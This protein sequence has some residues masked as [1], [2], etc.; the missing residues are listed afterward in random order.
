MKLKLPSWDAFGRALLDQLKVLEEGTSVY[1]VIE[2]DDGYIEAWDT[3]IYFSGPDEWHDAELELL[4]MVSSPI[5]DV[6]C[7][8][9]RH[10]LY[11]QEQG[12][13]VL[14]LDNSPGAIET[15][16][17]RGIK[18]V[19]LASAFNIPE[20]LPSLRSIILFGNNFGIGGSIEGCIELLRRFHH[21]S[22]DDCLLMGS[23]LNPLKTK[24]EFHLKYH[25]N[26][27]ACGLPVGRVVIRVRYQ[28]HATPFFQ[29][30]L[31][32]PEE[33]RMIVERSGWELEKELVDGAIHYFCL[34]KS[35]PSR[36]KPRVMGSC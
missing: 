11:L 25:E 28:C 9:G 5:L 21:V 30:L 29:L 24:N 2:R 12:F 16:L 8:A 1:H 3:S 31:P 6:G 27:S 19:L 20:S 32:T 35:H 13:E 10:A 18:K 17:Q 26:N 23:Y 36:W 14:A 22:T 33:F 4:R 34:K 15:C 7:G